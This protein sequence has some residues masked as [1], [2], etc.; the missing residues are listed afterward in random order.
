MYRSY[1][2]SPCV[3]TAN[4]NADVLM[5]AGGLQESRQRVHAALRVILFSWRMYMVDFYDN[6]R[7]ESAMIHRMNSMNVATDPVF[8]CDSNV[9]LSFNVDI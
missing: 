6:G 9:M 3:Q 8:C 2:M 5:T 7:S 1:C 4:E